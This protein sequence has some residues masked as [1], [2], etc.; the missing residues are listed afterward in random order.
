MKPFKQSL[1]ERLDGWIRKLNRINPLFRILFKNLM[2]KLNKSISTNLSELL[3]DH[4]LN[5]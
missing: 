4:K 1:R 2:S 5:S 3:S